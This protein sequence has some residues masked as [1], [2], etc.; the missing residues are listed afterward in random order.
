MKKWLCV[1]LI[2]PLAATAA[3]GSY[4]M[5][6]DGFVKMMRQP[7]KMPMPPHHYIEREKAY[8]Y[9]D[10]V[11]DSAEGR[12]W[13]DV[14]VLKTPD[15]AYEIAALIAKLPASERKENASQLILRQLQQLYPCQ[16]GRT[17]S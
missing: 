12:L 8:S 17:T 2:C 1:A 10:G 13:C 4:T 16:K 11:R 7:E 15:L 6:G 9:L 14:N 3:G 5:N